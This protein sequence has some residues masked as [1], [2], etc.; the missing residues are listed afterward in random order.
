[1]TKGKVI[2]FGVGKLLESNFKYLDFDN[3]VVF[4]DNN[5]VIQNTILC[6]KRV[7]PPSGIGEYEYDY[8]VIFNKNNAGIIHKQLL[9]MEILPDKIVS[10]QYYIYLY[11]LKAPFLSK[12]IV[13][14]LH[15]YI[16]ELNLDKIL[17]INFGLAKVNALFLSDLKMHQY[18]L[19]IIDACDYAS[20][21]KGVSFY[22]LYNNVRNSNEI[23]SENYDAV[24][25]L[26]TFLNYSLE[27]IVEIIE[28]MYMH[29]DYIVMNIPYPY[30]EYYTKWSDYD[31][32]EYGI[33]RK[34]N[35]GL[36][37]LLIME[38]KKEKKDRDVQIYVATHKEF[39]APNNSI[40]IPI[41]GGKKGKSTLRYIGDDTGDNISDANELINEC[42]VLYW[43]WKN[44]H[45]KY[46]GL[47]H[48]R[49]FLLKNDIWKDTENVLDD[50]QIIKIL[51]NYDFIVAEQV[52]TFPYT[53]KEHLKMSVSQA[54]FDFGYNSIRNIIQ[55]RYNEYLS[56]FDDYFNGY[57][58]YPCNLFVAAKEK[59]D[60]YCEWLFNII[61]EA[62]KAADITL[63]DSYSKR[64]IGFMAERLFTVWLIKN[65]Y[66][67]KECKIIKTD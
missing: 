43:V 23:Q 29:T 28:Q 48:Y 38:C 3:I 14:N 50:N 34:K 56:I 18:K 16:L 39:D 40:Y 8:I 41:H 37:Q 65:R 24:F 55:D 36:S 62:V 10:W 46:I 44:T 67:M 25:L 27:E 12:E 52:N 9:E 4:A 15:Y 31:F 22:C 51:S 54:A 47:N 66:K 53:V 21:R 5:P 58:F 32:S 35:L 11:S 7:I 26:D 13:D 17:D 57:V 42:T 59:A 49:R 61:L 1:M 2:I 20:S 64:I 6:G 30:P 33:V 19:P 60:Q 63:Y 45:N